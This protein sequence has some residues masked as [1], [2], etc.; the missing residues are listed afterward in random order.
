MKQ[1]S[2]MM[3][4]G[5]PAKPPLCIV[6]H[7]HVLPF[8]YGRSHLCDIIRYVVLVTMSRLPGVHSSQNFGILRGLDNAHSANTDILVYAPT[9]YE[10]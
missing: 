9:Q 5:L 6:E 3:R 4:Q 8:P 7:K 10:H 2:N 1:F